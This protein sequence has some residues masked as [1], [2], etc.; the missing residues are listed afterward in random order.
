MRRWGLWA[1]ATEILRWGEIAKGLMGSVV[2]VAVGEGVDEGLE[3]V[4]LVGELVGGVERVSP[5]WLGALDAAVEVGPLGRED[6]ELEAFVA[7][8]V[9]EEGHELGTAVDLDTPDFEGRARKQ[10][11][12]QDPCGAGG[13]GA[14]DVADRPFGDRIVGGEVF[15]RP[16][17]PDVDEEGVDLD[18]FAA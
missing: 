4:D 3:L 8:M 9:L 13:G 6:D 14:G 11:V 16:V 18:E 10:L 12:E 1:E 17:W 15:D 5:A 7:A 2:V